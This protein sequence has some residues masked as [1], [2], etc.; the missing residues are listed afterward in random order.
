MLVRFEAE[1][2][3]IFG[4]IFRDLGEFAELLQEAVPGLFLFQV[5]I[6]REL[7]LRWEKEATKSGNGGRKWE[8][9][10]FNRGK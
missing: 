5:F 6:I 3:T 8:F 2:N 1:K 10:P 9:F 7:I 4:V